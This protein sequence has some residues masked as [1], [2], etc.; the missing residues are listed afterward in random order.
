MCRPA[1]GPYAEARVI[2]RGGEDLVDV[3]VDVEL[4]E[5][6]LEIRHSGRTFIPCAAHYSAVSFKASF[7]ADTFPVS[8]GGPQSA[9]QV[10]LRDATDGNHLPAH[11]PSA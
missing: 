6:C 2:P 4:T 3:E 5:T 1:P 8:C 7:D 9:T 10:G 11:R